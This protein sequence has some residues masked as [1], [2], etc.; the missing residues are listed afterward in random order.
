MLMKI[1]PKKLRKACFV[2]ISISYTRLQM[3]MAHLETTRLYLTFGC[4]RLFYCF[5]YVF[6]FVVNLI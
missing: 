4:V 1:S 5:F 3:L 2:D 6:D